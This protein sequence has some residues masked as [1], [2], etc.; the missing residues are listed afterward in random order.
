MTAPDRIAI[1]LTNG[2]ETNW[3]GVVTDPFDENGVEY[4]RADLARTTS[5]AEA[6]A[7][8]EE[9]AKQIIDRAIERLRALPN[10]AGRPA[11]DANVAEEIR[12]VLRAIGEGKA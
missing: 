7:V 12:A 6:L 9:L 2:Y 1:K 4:V 3:W 10:H 8:P 11:W 5:L